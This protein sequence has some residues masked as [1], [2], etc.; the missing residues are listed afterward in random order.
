M[1]GGHASIHLRYDPFATAPLYKRSFGE[2]NNE[3]AP[4]DSIAYLQLGVPQYRISKMVETGGNVIDGY[5]WVNAVCP[6]GLPIRSI[7]GVRADPIMFLAV[8]CQDVAKSEEFYA[9][10]GFVRQEYPYARPNQ[11]QGQF[12]PP[13]PKKSVYVAP[14]PNSM[15]VLLLQN[16]KRKKAV[17]PNPV[18]RSLD[19]IYAPQDGENG[20]AFSPEDLDPKF[21][22][23]SSIPV[24]FIPSDYLENE[25]KKTELAE[26]ISTFQPESNLQT[27][28]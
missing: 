8:N 4:G 26:P 22:D 17:V 5:G 27:L 28:N 19:V 24:S 2:F 6:A 13:Q 15:G 11:G 18:L 1:Y 12:E 23:P 21:V 9:K 3:P 10:L 7:V 25:I 16:K 20:A 14:S